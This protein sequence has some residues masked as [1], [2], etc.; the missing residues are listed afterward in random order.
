MSR[1]WGH[2][3]QCIFRAIKERRTLFIDR[4]DD[5]VSARNRQTWLQNV[6]RED[7]LPVVVSMRRVKDEWRVYV[8]PFNER[9]ELPL[10]KT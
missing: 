10:V 4:Y 3:R 6:A 7:E 5:P 9:Q 1:P 2:G 8:M